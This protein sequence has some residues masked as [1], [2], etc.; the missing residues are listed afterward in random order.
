[1]IAKKPGLKT[2]IIIIVL[3]LFIFT[4]F[5]FYYY[6][7]AKREKAMLKMQRDYY[8]GIIQ[9][10]QRWLAELQLSN[11]ALPF[12]AAENG[13]A[14]IIPYFSCITALALLEEGPD[15]IKYAE[16]VKRYFD[17]HNAHLN[18]AAS[19]RHGVSGTIYNYSV[20]VSNGIVQSE[21]TEQKYDSTDSY[22]ALFLI[23]LWEYY[24]K[25][26]DTKLLVERYQNIN[27]VINAM[28]YTVD[29]DGLSFAKPGSR[30]KYLMDNAEVYQGLSSAINLLKK[31]FLPHYHEG[32]PEHTGA[33]EV[34]AHLQEIKDKQADSF[35][36][37]LWND[38]E[39]RYEVGIDKAGEPLAFK[40]WTCFYPDA[41]AQLFPI[42]YKVIETESEQA[43]YLYH[44]FGEHFEWGKLEHFENGHAS[45][46]WGLTAYCG[47]LMGDE[48]RVLSYLDCYL[49][50]VP[51]DYRYPAYNADVAWVV[52]A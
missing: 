32:T 46:Y 41:V 40:D 43:Q 49:Q 1:M 48:E 39:Q 34:L 33:S 10:E 6:R 15:G 36:K 22:A 2:G 14:A 44:T 23:A 26:G 35:A 45:F 37:L 51:P 8:L 24:N 19:D 12:R 7:S 18:N 20:E 25:T 5:L 3:I 13:P 31:V 29:T 27:D 11:G 47:A 21:E 42:I 17:W 30:V 16:A 9:S 38:T 28:I 4:A 50:K 52:M